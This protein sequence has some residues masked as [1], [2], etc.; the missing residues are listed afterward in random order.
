MAV[1]RGFDR[2][3][4]VDATVRAG[5]REATLDFSGV[6]FMATARLLAESKNPQIGIHPSLTAEM[7]YGNSELKNANRYLRP[8]KFL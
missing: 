6:D 7:R 8:L 4:S 5:F 2:D 3:A 1:E